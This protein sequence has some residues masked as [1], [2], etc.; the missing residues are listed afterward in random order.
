VCGQ[1]CSSLSG[2]LHDFLLSL[3]AQT[4]AALAELLIPHYVSASI[5]SIANKLPASTFHNNV[6]MLAV[7]GTAAAQCLLGDDEQ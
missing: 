5:F 6:K 3:A 1:R 7:S 4:L 2:T